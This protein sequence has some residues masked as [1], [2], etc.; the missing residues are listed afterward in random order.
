[1]EFG[2]FLF[3]TLH[4]SR[5]GVDNDTLRVDQVNLGAAGVPSGATGMLY[6][7]GFVSTRWSYIDAPGE[8]GAPREQQTPEAQLPLGETTRTVAYEYDA[9]NRLVAADYGDNTSFSYTYDASGNTLVAVK[10]IS[11]VSVTTTYTYNAD[12]ELV[13]AQEGSSP[14][15]NYSFDA[16][17][18]LAE[19][20]QGS[21]A[22]S[23]A[24]RY[25]YNTAGL[26]VKVETHDGTAY[27]TQAEM[28]YDGQGRRL[29]MTASQGGLSLTT[30]YLVDAAGVVKAAT[31]DSQTT[32]YAYGLG[33]LGE[34]KEAWS[35]YLNDGLSTTRQMSD[36]RGY[37][38]LS[39]S[40]TP[41][42]ELL[43]QNGQGDFSWGY[44]GGLL[45]AATGLIY[46]GS[47][48]YYDPA[49]GRFLTRGVY[50]GAPNPYVPWGD[51]LGV[52]VGPLALLALVRGK[53]KAGKIDQFLALGM[54]LLALSATVAGCGTPTS[55]ATST[56]QATPGST[57]TP[58]S[59]VT[60]YRT[61]S[62]T[63]TQTPTETVYVSLPSA[64]S[65][66]TIKVTIQPCCPEPSPTPTPTPTPDSGDFGI[67]YEGGWSEEEKRDVLAALSA[68]GSKIAAFIG[69]TSAS[70]F[71]AVFGSP[72]YFVKGG[73]EGG[74]QCQAGFNEGVYAISCGAFADI[75]DRFI[76]HELG[77]SLQQHIDGVNARQPTPTPTL[78]PYYSLAATAI[79]DDR[80]NWVTG[81][82]QETNIFERTTLGYL[83]GGIPDMYH[84]PIEFEH[85]WNSN[86]GYTA[87]NEDFADM[88]MN[89]VFHSFRYDS[90]A[91]GAG[92]KRDNWVQSNMPAWIA[93]ATR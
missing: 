3:H 62:P 61:G 19:A 37:V 82:H 28:V 84:G 26:L 23:G 36:A 53:R 74:E 2:L 63:P 44:F 8:P 33:V 65:T 77:H 75:T 49:T 92:N 30:A 60:A 50:P 48:Q 67:K 91:Y 79:K 35:Y 29:G 25:S 76:V 80:G 42:G 85:D 86:D 64:S 12:N 43:E 89:W 27:Q 4:V 46:V 45:D 90:D 41:C 20:M 68:V 72:L 54:I 51:P 24:R 16:N 32:Y 59:T 1:L 13:T 73:G 57:A 88:Y 58:P 10:T 9:L 31:A 78:G 93:L 81:T 5:T 15:W 17:G 40:F 6:L 39:R 70:A 55:T 14:A 52:I 11:G 38:T 69:G 18:S 87:R 7:D 83:S 71:M 21:Q 56:Q 34:K 22:G 47:G 66:P